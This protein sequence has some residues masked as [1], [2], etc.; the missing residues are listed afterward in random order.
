MIE[1]TITNG[2]ILPNSS[3]NL[4]HVIKHFLWLL[5]LWGFSE[6]KYGALAFQFPFYRMHTFRANFAPCS[7]KLVARLISFLKG[8]G[9]RLEGGE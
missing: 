4:F 7:K 2:M 9:C 5:Y 1:S 3:L 6:P 8:H